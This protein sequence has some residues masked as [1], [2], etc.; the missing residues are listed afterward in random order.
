MMVHFHVWNVV[1]AGLYQS[2]LPKL[3]VGVALLVVL[4]RRLEP[5]FGSLEFL[6]FLATVNVI[7]GVGTAGCIFGI[8][9]L[10]R[11]MSVLFVHISGVDGLVVAMLMAATH[12][13][14]VGEK[15]P[16]TALPLQYV[17][18][19]FFA[20]QTLYW[21]IWEP[22]YYDLPFTWF[23][24][25]AS[26]WFLRFLRQNTDG[27]VGDRSERFEFVCLFPPPLS[28]V[29]LPVSN[30]FF[31][32]FVLFGFFADRR[33]LQPGMPALTV[34]GSEGVFYHVAATSAEAAAADTAAAAAAAAAVQADIKD[35]E[36]QIETPAAGD[37]PT[38]ARQ[39]A[40]AEEELEKM[41]AAME[42][43]GQEDD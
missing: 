26:W 14:G 34:A 27:S 32:F 16:G 3:V 19:A 8:Y 24:F 13:S 11:S 42:A 23:G 7:A 25:V 21:L 35:L 41:L 12:A 22:S 15:V 33:A 37:D 2:S 38:A 17:P 6:R 36:V 43:D 20:A 39:R 18:F 31:G 29:M 30:F 40:R 10:T 1:T 28:R 5:R 4:G 9:I